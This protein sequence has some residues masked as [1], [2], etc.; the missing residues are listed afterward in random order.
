MYR[1]HG[2]HEPKP[3]EHH[4]Y[5]V[6]REHVANWLD[7]L[8]YSVYA[9]CTLFCPT[10]VSRLCNPALLGVDVLG[11]DVLA[12]VGLYDACVCV[13]VCVYVCVCVCVCVCVYVCVCVC[14]CLCLCACVCTCVFVCVQHVCV[15]V[16]AS[17]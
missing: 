15:C 9:L 4:L 14:A 5:R 12:V 8:I 2:N 7:H 16:C 17:L 11:V 6:R 3:S 1:N 10:F 13:Y